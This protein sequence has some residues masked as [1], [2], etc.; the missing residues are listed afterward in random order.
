MPSVIS[1]EAALSTSEVSS[2][3]GFQVSIQ[4]LKECGLSPL[5]DHPM[6]SYWRA[7]D[8]PLICVAISRH[9]DRLAAAARSA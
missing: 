1:G 5:S 8:F 6:R 7:S 2:M 3:L 9:L 4:Y